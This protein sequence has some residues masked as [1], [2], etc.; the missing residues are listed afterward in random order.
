MNL[1]NKLPLCVTFVALP[2]AAA[3]PTDWKHEQ[4]FNVSAPGLVKM[5]LPVETLDAARPA[6]EDLRLYDDGSAQLFS[7]F[8]RFFF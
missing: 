4:Q 5:S 7:N 1:R 6:L 3:L 8:P 2:L